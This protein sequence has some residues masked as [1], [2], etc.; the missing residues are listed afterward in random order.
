VGKHYS[1]RATTQYVNG[2]HRA[3]CAFLSGVTLPPSA[4]GQDVSDQPACCSPR[5]PAKCARRHF[6][7]P[8]L[9]QCHYRL[10]DGREHQ[11][12]GSIERMRWP[13]Q[14]R[15]WLGGDLR[16]LSRRTG[17]TWRASSVSVVFALPPLRIFRS[18]LFITAA[19]EVLSGAS[20]VEDDRD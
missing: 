1:I 10:I 20:L 4:N 9:A 19:A 5:S 18:H 15:T 12:M 3:V 2:N 17:Q 8:H 11:R 16:R 14:H 13:K 6:T 7:V